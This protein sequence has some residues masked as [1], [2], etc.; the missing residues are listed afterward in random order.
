M[1]VKTAKMKKYTIYSQSLLFAIF[2]LCSCN[3]GFLNRYPMDEISSETFWNSENDLRIYNNGIYDIT[4]GSD[5]PIMLGHEGIDFTGMV[6]TAD[7][8]TDN[9]APTVNIFYQ[10]VRSGKFTVPSDPQPFGYTGWQL[11]RACNIGLENYNRAKIDQSIIDKY[12]AEAR[13]FR[14]WFYA[15]K[16]EMFGDVPWFDTELN[17]DS[18]ELYED[19]TPRDSVMSKVLEDLNF[20][21][22][23]LPDDW[24]DGN[25]PGRL[26]RWAALLLKSRICLFEGTWQKYRGGSNVNMWLQEAAD[27]AKELIENGPY[28]LFSTGDPQHDYNTTQRAADLTGN[29]EVIYWKKYKLGIQTNSVMDWYCAR[30]GYGGATKSLVEDYLCTDGLPITTSP[31]YMGDQVYENIFQNRDP[32]LRQTILDPADQAYYNYERNLTYSY[33]RVTGMDGGTITTTGYHVIKMYN[34]TTAGAT[35]GT[36]E[37][38]AI[39]MRLGEALLNYAEA[40]AELGSITQADVDLSINK[41]RD[42]VGM[43]HLDMSNVPVDPRYENDG[44]SPLIVEIRRERR[45][46][47]C[48]EGK[49]RYDDLRRWKQGKKLE[50]PTLGMRWDN[51]NSSRFDPANAATVKTTMVSGVKYIDVYQGTDFANPTFDENKDY[52]WPIPLSVM[53]QNAN[54]SQNPG[55]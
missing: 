47:L 51:A 10:Q 9:L 21:C 31:L 40:K 43:P 4:L 38:P 52:L 45:V 13:L 50:I 55:W 26:N 20:A 22:E 14:G 48:F 44:V 5:V 29:P 15:D 53:A 49:F 8:F 19:R 24:D 27:A 16:V 37:T 36:A 54:I 7:E 23:K 6:W 2:L 42:R 39:V 12:A 25:A 32:R 11:V 35:F 41:L 17:I 18:K 28:S 1:I 3:K 46:E 33:P 34:S 30:A